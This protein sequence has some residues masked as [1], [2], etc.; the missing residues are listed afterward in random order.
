M[1][2]R[3][4]LVE[5]A[6]YRWTLRHPPSAEALIDEA[7][8]ERDERLPYWAD[9]WP[10]AR[11]LAGLVARHQGHGRR[12][13]ELGCG[14]GL[15]ACALAAAGYD[16]LATD[17]Y[18]AALDTTAANV[19]H[20]TGRDVRTRLV[21][22]RALPTDLGTFA[23]V[24]AA[25]VLYERPH[26]TL[27]ARALATTLAP[28]GMGIVADPGRIALEGF[29]AECRSLGLVLDEQWEVPHAMEGQQ[30]VIRVNVL[31]WPAPAPAAPA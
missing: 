15:V 4:T 28:D 8:F 12:A 7:E 11:V 23:L 26:A 2:A 6:G 10:S 30:H 24:A 17:Y 18:Q 25:D 19:R 29:L 21:D 5:A 9:I 27:V 31:R 14:S 13:L 16:V 22:W 3:E 20:N 1:E